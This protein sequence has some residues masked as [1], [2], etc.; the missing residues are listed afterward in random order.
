MRVFYNQNSVILA[1]VIKRNEEIYFNYKSSQL[2]ILAKVKS[3][4]KEIK[5]M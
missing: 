3:N 2:Q 5:W 1:L 4:F